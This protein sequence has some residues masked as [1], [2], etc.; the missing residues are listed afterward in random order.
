MLDNTT[1][2]QLE[3]ELKILKDELSTSQQAKEFQLR[4]I[5][6]FENSIA[7]CYEVFNKLDKYQEHLDKKIL[8]IKH[9]LNAYKQISEPEAEPLP[10]IDNKMKE[11]EPLPNID[12]KMKEYY[13][14]D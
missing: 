1:I 13:K 12:N 6:Q 14:I 7:K 11:A 8:V 10:N 4:E 3:I 2:K 9:C 5:K